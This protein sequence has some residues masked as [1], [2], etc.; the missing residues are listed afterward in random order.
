[1]KNTHINIIEYKYV[2][3]AALLFYIHVINDYN[4]LEYSCVKKRVRHVI[5]NWYGLIKNIL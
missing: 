5:I 2:G 1:M 4:M 3:S